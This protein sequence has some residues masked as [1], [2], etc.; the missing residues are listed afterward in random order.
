MAG[1]RRPVHTEIMATNRQWIDL[2]QWALPR[3][4]MRWAGFR[5]VH[6]QVQKRINRR[7]Q[8]LG[9]AGPAAYRD[10]LLTHPGEWRKLDALCR[11]SIS[12]FC[13]DRGFYTALATGIMPGLAQ[14][15]EQDSNKQLCIWSA[16]CASGEEPYSLTILWQLQLE[17]RFPGI[18]LAI[19]AS[20][21]DRHLLQRARRACYPASSLR[22]LSPAWRRQA[23]EET[24]GEYCLKR[25]FTR[26]VL[27]VEHDIRTPPPTR[28]LHLILCRNLVY[29]YYQT[30]LQR[31][32]TTHLQAALRP[33]GLLVLGSH[34]TLPAGA[35]GLVPLD[36]RW[37]V[38][39]KT[40]VTQLRGR[41]A[42]RS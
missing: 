10:Y 42:Q 5:K 41:S 23:F 14:E 39:R 32:I 25:A 4:H 16:G 27:L 1:R 2:L 40:A 17:S 21:S 24:G 12:R 8:S 20:D 34:E 36:G 31:E 37:P 18:D 22:D 33:G 9:L 28:D 15:A 6:G 3:L 7:L 35:A 13:R 30:D 26:P 38:Y 29:T 11:I 19:L